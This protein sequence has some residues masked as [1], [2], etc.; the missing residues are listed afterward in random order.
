MEGSLFISGS[1]SKFFTQAN[2]DRQRESSHAVYSINRD[3]L[4]KFVKT[5]IIGELRLESI[6]KI[7]ISHTVSCNK[8]SGNDLIEATD[9][10]SSGTSAELA[11]VM[12]RADID[13][14]NIG[15][16]KRKVRLGSGTKIKDLLK[17][18]ILFIFLYFSTRGAHEF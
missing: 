9:F 10:I 17:V 16:N 2:K 8:L 4:N 13:R 14:K 1:P 6:S 7:K 3:Y 5:N 12:V 15:L 11:R 18:C